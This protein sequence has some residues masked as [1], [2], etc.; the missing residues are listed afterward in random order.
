MSAVEFAME[1]RTMTSWNCRRVTLAAAL[2]VV[3]LVPGSTPAECDA[4]SCA[5]CTSNTAESNS[6]CDSRGHGGHHCGRCRKTLLHWPCQEIEFASADDE[7]EPLATDRP[8][9]TEASS[10]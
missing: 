10:T 4:V 8:D 9:F 7:E 2:L 6:C 1:C 5:S 3:I